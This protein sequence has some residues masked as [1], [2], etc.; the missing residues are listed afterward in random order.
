LLGSLAVCC[1]FQQGLRRSYSRTASCRS[2]GADTEGFPAILFICDFLADL[3]MTLFWSTDTLSA[4]C[5]AIVMMSTLAGRQLLMPAITLTHLIF[6][7]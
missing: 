5:M 1:Y 7:F 3:A 2:S 6:H 4:A